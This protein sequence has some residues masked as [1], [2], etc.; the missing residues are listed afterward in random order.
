MNPVQ[1]QATG[2]GATPEL[3]VWQARI[4]LEQTSRK[5]RALFYL[6][7]VQFEHHGEHGTMDRKQQVTLACGISLLCEGVMTELDGCEAALAEADQQ[8]RAVLK[9]GVK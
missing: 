1:P 7:G 3:A 4:D 9:G 8:V 2:Q 5:V 6:L